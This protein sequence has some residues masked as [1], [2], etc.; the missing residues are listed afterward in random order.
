MIQSMLQTYDQQQ[1]WQPFRVPSRVLSAI[2]K[3]LQSN[4]SLAILFGTTCQNMFVCWRWTHSEKCMSYAAWALAHIMSHGSGCK[5]HHPGMLKN[6][7]PHIVIDRFDF[8]ADYYLKWQDLSKAPQQSTVHT[9]DYDLRTRK[10]TNTPTVESTF[11]S[12]HGSN[13]GAWFLPQ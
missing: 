2:I 3:F 9:G 1:I 13:S 6:A 12:W 10:H 7:W 4:Q 5:L 8:T 11:L